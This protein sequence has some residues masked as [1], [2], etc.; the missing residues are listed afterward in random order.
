MF[1]DDEE[2]EDDLQDEEESRSMTHKNL[3]LNE[4]GCCLKNSFKA[5]PNSGS[6]AIAAANCSFGSWMTIC[7]ET[8]II[9]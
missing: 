9:F 8:G 4:E 5:D 1:L 7:N 2:R 3:F 6:I